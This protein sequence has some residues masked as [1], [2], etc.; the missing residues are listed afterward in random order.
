[1]NNAVIGDEFEID[2]SLAQMQEYNKP[3]ASD[4]EEIDIDEKKGKR[5]TLGIPL[6]HQLMNS[7]IFDHFRCPEHSGTFSF[8]LYLQYISSQTISRLNQ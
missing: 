2:R 3:M 6:P 1:M 8:P 7:D 4:E 5:Y